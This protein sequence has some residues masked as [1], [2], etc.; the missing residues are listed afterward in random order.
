MNEGSDDGNVANS[1]EA[2]HMT[3]YYNI[4]HCDNAVRRYDFHM[5]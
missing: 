4:A 3:Y 1:F 2:F 5:S